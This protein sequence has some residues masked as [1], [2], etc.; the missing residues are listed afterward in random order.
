MA[1]CTWWCYV[2]KLGFLVFLFPPSS[3]I[4]VLLTCGGFCGIRAQVTSFP[5]TVH[6]GCLG[7][8]VVGMQPE[9]GAGVFRALLPTWYGLLGVT[10][11]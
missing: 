7:E 11:W 5:F 4:T 6:M 8:G 2:S 1:V 9:P 10:R 3:D